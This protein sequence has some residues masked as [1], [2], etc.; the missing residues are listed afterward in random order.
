ML[1]ALSGFKGSGKDYVGQILVDDYDFYAVA[2]ADPI[3][4]HVM[5]IFG[6]N[7]TA[8]YDTFKRD[9]LTWGLNDCK[10][11]GRQVVREIGMLMRSYDEQQFVRQ[12]ACFWEQ[13]LS[14]ITSVTPRRRIVIT[15][16]RFQ[17]ELDWVRSFGGVAVRIERDGTESDGHVTEQRLSIDMVIDNNSSR[18][19]V[20]QQLQSILVRAES[21]CPSY[22]LNWE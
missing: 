8:E 17:N 5:E 22:D 2:F 1:I 19:E 6:L 15:D 18:E 16:L 3:K 9:V 4:R 21:V 7:T 14:G 12:V 20:K 11:K 10:V 13:V